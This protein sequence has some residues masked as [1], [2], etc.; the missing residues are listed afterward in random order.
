MLD[1]RR[2]RLMARMAQYEKNNINKDLKISTYYKKD[3]ASL[4]MLITILWMTVGYGILLGL[5]AVCFM[6]ELLADLTVSKLIFLCA[7][8][9]VGYLI[10]LVIYAVCSNAFYRGRH[11]DAKHRVKKYYRDLSRLGKMEV[12][13]KKKE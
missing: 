5:L 8:A 10:L 13:E 12:K 3:Y 9:G 7:E 11:N 1:T 6:D 4:N 2:I